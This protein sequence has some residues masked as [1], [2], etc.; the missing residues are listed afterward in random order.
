MSRGV[1]CCRGLRQEA[2]SQTTESISH[3]TGGAAAERPDAGSQR[4]KQRKACPQGFLALPRDPQGPLPGSFPGLLLPVHSSPQPF[5]PVFLLLPWPPSAA[6]PLLGEL[7]V[8]PKTTPRGDDSSC[9]LPPLLSPPWEV[10]VRFGLTASHGGRF[11]FQSHPLTLSASAYGKQ[12]GPV[13]QRREGG[14][15]RKN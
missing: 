5:P 1:G 7:K 14:D 8:K 13:R 3:D 15:G 2:G 12:L 11:A 6:P 4:G 10:A 9:F